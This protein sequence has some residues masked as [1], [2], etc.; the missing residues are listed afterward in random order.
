MTLL[1]TQQNIVSVDQDTRV[2]ASPQQSWTLMPVVQASSPAQPP[3]STV[4]AATIPATTPTVSF[5]F[6]RPRLPA[7]WVQAASPGQTS[8]SSR[9]FTEPPK[10]VA[11]PV[12]SFGGNFFGSALPGLSSVSLF[13][14]SNNVFQTAAVF[15]DSGSSGG[16][17]T[18]QSTSFF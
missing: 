11:T 13:A 14:G 17:P 8:S 5:E 10:A 7:L 12:Q 1:T 6:A 16:A 3:A 15:E 4:S 18:G 9:P 2:T